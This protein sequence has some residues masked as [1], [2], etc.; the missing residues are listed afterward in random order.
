MSSQ[1]KLILGNGLTILGLIVLMPA[2]DLDLRLIGFHGSRT[3]RIIAALFFMA[4]SGIGSAADLSQAVVRQKVNVV[5]LA[6]NLTA[7]PR[8]AAQGA[9]VRNEN[10]VR[11]GTESRAELEFTDLTL[12]RLG[13]NSIFSFDAQAR[14]MTFTRGAVLFSKPTNSGAIE[15]RSGA[16]T[17]AI[18]G[19]TGFISNVP[20]GGIKTGGPRQPVQKGNTTLVGM[21]EGKLV[22]GAHWRD[23]RGREQTTNFHLGP[24]EMLVAQ[25]GRPPIIAQFDIPRFLRT[26]PLITGFSHP[27]PNQLELDRAV[28]NYRADERRGFIEQRNVLVS[29][30]PVQVAWT[31]YNSPNRGSFDASVAQLGRMSQSTSSGGG[32]VNVGGTGIIRGQLVWDTSADLDLH[33]TLP[34]QQQVYYANRSV[35][36]NGGKATATLDHDN[37]G[38]TIDAAPSHRVENIVVNGVPASGTYSFFVNSFS[39]PNS[40]DPFSLR[41]SFNGHT[42]LLTGNLGPEQNS[43]PVI[44]QVPPGG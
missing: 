34:D 19:S 44:V 33:L 30:Q 8:P 6:P 15:L 39:T 24:G 4:L 37:L 36:F 26:C 43:T 28:A 22:G 32:F 23:N 20:I 41:V 42:Q 9:V 35:T 16:I 29:S 38:G 11:T 3:L 27:L 10:V 21:L 40:S 17:A 18:T 14:A 25:P 13:S 2:M 5:T 7:E 12:A 1:P 31:G